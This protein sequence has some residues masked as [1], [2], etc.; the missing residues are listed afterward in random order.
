MKKLIILS[1]ALAA[2]AALCLGARDAD[3][4][5]VAPEFVEIDRVSAN[6]SGCPVGTVTAE[7]SPDRQA[8]T[9]VFA[10]FD[11]AVGPDVD[12]ARSSEFCNVSVLLD[13]PG[14]WSY[15]LI[16]SDY[17]GRANLGA[18]VIGRQQ[19]TYWFQGAFSRRATFSTILQ[20]PFVGD[21]I[22]RDLLDTE[23]FVWSPCGTRRSMNINSNVL[24][25]LVNPEGRGFMN[26]E[27]N[28]IAV[29]VTYGL[30]WRLCEE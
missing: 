1:A 23:A 11:A 24:V 30:T 25:S 9:L 10:D 4:Q 22:R 19:A 27:V 28:E 14:G 13:Y 20:G 3:A 29:R 16:S 6:G 18:G 21:Y 15:S 26:V 8:L 12:P 17:F 2:S 7:I 5:L